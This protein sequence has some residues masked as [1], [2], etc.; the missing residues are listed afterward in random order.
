MDLGLK[1]RSALVTGA[2]AGIGWAIADGLAH[3]GARVWITGRSQ[4]GVD[5]ALARL[6]QANPGCEARG[7]AA[8]CASAEVPTSPPAPGRFSMT[9]GCPRRSPTC[10]LSI[11]SVMSLA[12]PAA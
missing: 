1:G 11:R 3:E 4:A 7:V 9:I 6:E 2:T 5:A 10:L 12:P 8:D